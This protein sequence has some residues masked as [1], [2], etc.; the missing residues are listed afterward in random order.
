MLSPGFVGIFA[1]AGHHRV[2]CRYEGGSLKIAL[3]ALGLAL[4]VAM[5]KFAGRLRV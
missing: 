5:P 4:L 3:L 2:V 1:A